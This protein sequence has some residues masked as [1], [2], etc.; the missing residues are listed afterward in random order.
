MH[1]GG[2]VGVEIAEEVASREG[3]D[4]T[5]L[6]PPLYDV[7]DLEALDA[8]L[9]SSRAGETTVKF[10]YAQYRIVVDNA[11]SVRVTEPSDT[12][13]DVRSREPQSSD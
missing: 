1:N 4:P 11:G 8:F 13:A 6:E 5:D 9:Q 10:R 7:V 12:G 3:V 2:P